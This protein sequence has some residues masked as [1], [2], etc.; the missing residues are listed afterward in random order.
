MWEG[1]LGGMADQVLW[2]MSPSK[3]LLVITMNKDVHDVSQV[4]FSDRRFGTCIQLWDCANIRSGGGKWHDL[5]SG[6]P[7]DK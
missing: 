7:N 1:F 6:W 2:G 5:R 4:V 3:I